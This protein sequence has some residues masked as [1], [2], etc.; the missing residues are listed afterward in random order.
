[1]QINARGEDEAGIGDEL[2]IMGVREPGFRILT[3]EMGVKER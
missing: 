3:Y 2:G 1:M